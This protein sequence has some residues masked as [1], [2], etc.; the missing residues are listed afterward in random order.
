MYTPTATGQMTSGRG[1]HTA[2]LLNNG[3]VLIAGGS[4]DEV[5][6]DGEPY[7]KTAELYTPDSLIGPPALFSL[8]GDGKGAGAI[9]H[10][11]TG[12]VVSVG[13]PAIAG[14]ALSMYTSN[15]ANNGA[16]PPKVIIGD[17]FAEVLYFG[18][19]PG[20][21]GYFQ[22]NFLMP[23]DAHGSAVPVRVMY[24]DRSSNEV[25]TSVQ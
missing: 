12:T 16:I 9:W 23:S 1:S 17:R 11:N 6:S 5:R 14:E 4:G 19:A 25:T 24:L 15:L 3:K 18:P 20:Y 8:S 2:T 10:S 13:N 22:L 7:L 21:P